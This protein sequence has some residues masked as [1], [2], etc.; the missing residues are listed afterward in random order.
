MAKKKSP[1]GSMTYDESKIQTLSALEHIR[2]RPGMYIGRLGDGS[3]FEDGIY[4]LI[5]EVV[6]NSVDEFIM[7]SGNR[8]TIR[9]KDNLVSVRDYGR[10]IPLGKVVECV[11]VINTGGKFNDDVFQFSVGLN[12]VGTK[13]VNAL[14]SHFKVT[15]FREGT[16]FEAIFSQGKLE[17][18]KRGKSDESDGTLIEFI[19]DNSPNIFGEYAFQNEF[20]EERLWNYAYLNTGLT[21]DFNRKLF[22]SKNGLLD[23]LDKHVGGTASIKQSI[24]ATRRLNLPLPTPTTMGRTTSPT[25]TDNTPATGGPTSQL[26]KRGSLG[27][28]TSSLRSRTAPPMYATA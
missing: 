7:E 20:I 27:G 28:S 24:T 23:L 1:N 16:F 25:S 22:S 26:L 12:G 14:S 11:S 6:D 15:S 9:L 3:H 21:L 10:G 18:E 8:I 2:L 13:A 19:P 4:I 5:K 17:S